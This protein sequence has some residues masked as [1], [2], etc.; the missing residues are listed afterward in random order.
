MPS[1][2]RDFKLDF[3]DHSSNSHLTFSKV[4]ILFVLMQLPK[5][6]LTNTQATEFIPQLHKKFMYT[7]NNMKTHTQIYISGYV[8]DDN[9]PAVL[10]INKNVEIVFF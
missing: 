7:G 3:V 4:H 6:S 5:V 8:T 2:I 10:K 9:M 1:K